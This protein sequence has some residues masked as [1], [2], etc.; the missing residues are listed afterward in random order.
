M[1][2]DPTACYGSYL[3]MTNAPSA[4]PPKP[5]CGTKRRLEEAPVVHASPAI[6]CIASVFMQNDIL[7]MHPTPSLAA[8]EHM[9]DTEVEPARARPASK[10]EWPGKHAGLFS[11]EGGVDGYMASLISD[12]GVSLPKGKAVVERL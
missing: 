12:N 1:S 2:F 9:E 8:V 7:P 3:H 6:P 5:S 4:E 10:P 11:E